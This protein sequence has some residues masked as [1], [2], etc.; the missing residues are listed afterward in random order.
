MTWPLLSGLISVSVILALTPGP[1]TLLTLRCG[2]RS[3]TA[4]YR[5]AAGAAAGIV[6]WSL[7]A[8]TG[9]RLALDAWPHLLPTVTAV[10]GL[11]ILVL[12]L[13]ALRNGLRHHTSGAALAPPSRPLAVGLA[14]SLTNP[15]TGLIFLA[16]FPRVLPAELTVGSAVVVPAIAAG[17]VGLWLVVLASVA[18]RGRVGRVLT[19]SAF[20][21]LSGLVLAGMGALALVEGLSH[22]V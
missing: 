22:A 19:G 7:F 1:D 20:E 3:A 15:K 6:V 17:S 18:G 13:L 2:A 9:L 16:A 14:S 5:Y 10:G 8:L 12:G 11:L 21:I 4:G